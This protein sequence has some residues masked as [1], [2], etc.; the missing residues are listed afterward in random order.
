MAP[1]GKRV[2]WLCEMPT[3]AEQ[4]THELISTVR[5]TGGY[6]ITETPVGLVLTRKYFPTWRIF[7]LGIPALVLGRKA[8]MASVIVEPLTA[9][10][11]QLSVSGRLVSWM[12]TDI[13][14]M[15]ERLGASPA[16]FAQ[17]KTNG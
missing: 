1:K 15:L 8:E 5:K 10:S 17:R 9:S 4:L 16:D 11:A 14:T 12:R 3:S 2:E 13:R 7:V 6:G